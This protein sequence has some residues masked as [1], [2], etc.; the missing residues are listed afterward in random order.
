M[1]SIG[2]IPPLPNALAHKPLI[3]PIQ[4]CLGISLCLISC[5][6]FKNLFFTSSSVTINGIVIFSSSS[7]KIDKLI[8]PIIS[9]EFLL[10][11]L[12]QVRTCNVQ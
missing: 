7:R 11:F 1:V 2:I 6:S 12:L 4:G 8:S 5:L 9:K 10:I 3:V